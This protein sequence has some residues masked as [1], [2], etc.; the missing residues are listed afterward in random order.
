MQTTKLT[1][2]VFTPFNKKFNEVLNALFLKRDSF[3]DHLI[4]SELYHLEKALEGKR[5]SESAKRYINNGMDK[6][7]SSTALTVVVK[8]QTAERLRKI[9]SKH[10]INRDAFINRLFLFMILKSGGLQRLG[11]LAFSLQIR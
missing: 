3:L 7:R 2:H 4:S 8:K 6:K 11:A 9:V 1:F 10:N 5:N